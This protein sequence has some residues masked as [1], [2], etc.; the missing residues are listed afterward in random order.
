MTASKLQLKYKII[1]PENYLKTSF[2]ED[3]ETRRKGINR[4]ATNPCMVVENQKGY[5]SCRG[6]H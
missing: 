3:F 2:T 5:L 4:L 1:N 6:T